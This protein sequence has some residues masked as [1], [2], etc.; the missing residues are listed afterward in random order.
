M[1]PAR[2]LQAAFLAQALRQPDQI[3]LIEG[4]RRMS[5]LALLQAAW[6]VASALRERGLQRGQLVGLLIARSMEAVVAILG[7]LMAGGRWVPMDPDR[8]LAHLEFIR[9]DAQLRLLVTRERRAALA[10]QLIA[11]PA[12]LV[13]RCSPPLPPEA[14][15]QAAS[16]RLDAA[17]LADVEPSLGL[18]VLYTSG[19][20]G[21]AKGVLGT[22]QATLN[23]LRWM[24]RVLP[25]EPHEVLAHRAS[26]DFV[27]SVWE[28]FGGLL[29]GTPT[30]IIPPHIAS[31]MLRMVDALREAQ[32]TRLTLV[33]SAL[34][35]LL[36]ARPELGHDLPKLR[37]WTVS[38]EALTPGLL[39]R[40]NAA[41]PQATLLNLYGSTEVAADVTWARFSGP[42]DFARDPVPIGAPID[43]AQLRV[44]D[45]QGRP[46][47]PGVVGELWV[48]GPVLAAG[49]HHRP[50]E[51]AERFI[52]DEQGQPWFR[53]GDRVWLGQDG[54][55]YYVGRRDHQV[56]LRG[57]RVELAEVEAALLTA[58]PGVKHAAAVVQQEGDDEDSRCLVGFIAPALATGAQ[59]R[60]ALAQ[61]V[62]PHII[63]ARVHALDALP[64]TPT[65]KLD[66]Q[67]LMA[68]RGRALRVPAAAEAISL[69]QLI[70][71]IWQ[72]TLQ[73]DEVHPE[74]DFQALG[75]DSL[76]WVNALVKLH[77]RLERPGPI[78]NAPPPTTVARLAAWCRG[79]LT[80]RH[81][82]Q[83]LQLRPLDA[84]WAEA[85]E[86]AMATWFTERDPTTRALGISAQ[87]FLPYARAITRGCL[88]LGY[89]L[90]AVDEEERLVGFCISDDYALRLDL[91]PLPEVI[92]PVLDFNQRLEDADAALHGQ[93]RV[94]GHTLEL[95]MTAAAPDEDGYAIIRA[96]EQRALIDGA[97]RG[98][99]RAVTVC[100]HPVTTFLAQAL[101]FE[102][103][104]F[105]DYASYEHRGRRP[106]ASLAY[107]HAGARF[108]ARPL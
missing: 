97:A 67:A 23:R 16:Q 82:P 105:L 84:S 6:G 91:G 20:T 36:A 47:A 63:P 76:G 60:A 3:A 75:G 64:M 58:L 19:S 88:R 57:V 62:L 34:S 48:G 21:R 38:G 89:S 73:V 40:F 107:E 65:G 11:A 13:E 51:T 53:T 69:E 17:T 102:Q 95:A 41:A 101:G 42:E 56:K 55:L 12:V 79:E 1:S 30:V 27:D 5:Y 31:D 43:Q 18:Y 52:P 26:L 96:L 22:H 14:L 15:L 59:V 10:E 72:D 61:R 7:V 100:T 33:P 104:A 99:K 83:D 68:Y 90:V 50:Q 98:F 106:L 103:V 4:Q 39:R 32:A 71:Q 24:W 37:L 45:D 46:C 8:P 25:F 86:V 35:T 70:G 28:I 9:D 54:L 80:P 2:T 44:L 74:D 94:L 87:D 29:T 77:A 85:V 81:K 49:Y 66:R 78:L 108:M 93:E 92:W